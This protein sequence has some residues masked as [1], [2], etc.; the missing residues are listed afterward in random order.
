MRLIIG[1][2]HLQS[3]IKVIWNKSPISR[4]DYIAK[5]YVQWNNDSKVGPRYPWEIRFKACNGYQ[6]PIN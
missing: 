4:L 1:I 5:A 3:Y 6:N 2:K